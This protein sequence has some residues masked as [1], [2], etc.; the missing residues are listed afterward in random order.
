MT[1][2]LR[3][4]SPRM[5]SLRDYLI[6]QGWDNGGDIAARYII[7]GWYSVF[8]YHAEDPDN[9]NDKVGNEI[10]DAIKAWENT[11]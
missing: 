5:E 6:E 8:E 4:E 11:K 2:P 9:D 10:L 1:E 7:N 3:F